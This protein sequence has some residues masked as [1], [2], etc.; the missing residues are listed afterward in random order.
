MEER[1]DRTLELGTAAVVDGRGGESLPHDVL[2]DVGGDEQRDSRAKTVALLQ[3]L[4]L[5]AQKKENNN[6]NNNKKHEQIMSKKE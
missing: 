4:I 3:K 5:H 6:N 1:D 2:A